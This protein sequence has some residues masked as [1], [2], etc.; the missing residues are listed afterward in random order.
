MIGFLLEMRTGINN[1]F[2]W[3]I[4]LGKSFHGLGKYILNP[5]ISGRFTNRAGAVAP[6]IDINFHV[7]IITKNENFIKGPA[8][9]QPN[10]SPAI[11][12]QL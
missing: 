9:V 10:K 6:G 11:E 8:L 12:K 2:H 5:A 7:I 4:G 1:Q 3:I